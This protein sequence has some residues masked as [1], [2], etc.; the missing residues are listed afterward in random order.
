[1]TMNKIKAEPHACNDMKRTSL[2][3]SSPSWSTTVVLVGSLASGVLASVPIE[4]AHADQP[5]S[6]DCRVDTPNGLIA[7]I[8]SATP[9]AV[10]SLAQGC[11]Y[12]L[13]SPVSNPPDPTLGD[14]GLLITKML[15]I[16]GNGATITRSSAQKFR[17]F[18]VASSGVDLTLSDLTVD[19][20]D[21]SGT[22]ADPKAGRGGGILNLGTLNVT[23]STFSHNHA[24]F[25]APG[26]GNGIPEEGGVGP[27]NLMLSDSV[28]FDNGGGQ[29]GGAIGNG[30]G[31]TMHLTGCIISHN[32]A[33]IEGGGIANQGT[34][35]LNKCTIS[36]NSA[37][38]GGG[39]INAGQM[40]LTDSLVSS[41]NA[42]AIT[43][44]TRPTQ[45]GLGGGLLNVASGTVTLNHT[46]V[47]GNS[48][49]NG[50]GGIV[51]ASSPGQV[52]TATVIDSDVSSN[53]TTG[54]NPGVGG[55]PG[56]G[57]GILN[58]GNMSLTHS[59]VTGNNA[60]ADG[61]GIYNASEPIS[62]AALA[63]LTLTHSDV[64]NNNAGQGHH[65]GGIF[66]QDG[67]KVRVNQTTVVFNTPD[68]CSGVQPTCPSMSSAV[69]Q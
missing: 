27:G 48:A 16:K 66:N 58:G 59:N 25:G 11:V 22:D 43:T 53:S 47:T 54:V 13:T 5:T 42:P 37:S 68:E 26:I 23:N 18:L 60:T 3:R 36:G 41:N 51:N 35:I 57:A 29:I 56:I 1:M 9:G 30:G 34:A 20:G 6:V 32:T 64:T 21:T 33:S 28:F 2:E 31:S 49:T 38:L 8:N 39:I 15:T 67:N 10:L 12:V 4:V 45:S 61:G 40:F 69:S 63:D 52:G 65:G 17:I 19:N 14:S 7:A 44:I 24:S 55:F 46:D 50:G 62:S